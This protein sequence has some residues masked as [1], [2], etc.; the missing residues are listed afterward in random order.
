MQDAKAIGAALAAF[1]PADKIGWKPQ[2]VKNNRAM[3]VAYIDARDV[4]DRLDEAVGPANWQDEYTPLG[5]GSVMCRLSVRFGAEWIVK[6]DV[7]SPSEQP[8]G[9]DRLKAAFSDALK[10]AAVKFGVGRYLYSLPHSWHDYDPAKRQFVN[11]PTLPAKFLPQQQKPAQ[12]KPAA[13]VA[14][15]PQKPAAPQQASNAP[16]RLNGWSNL[17][18]QHFDAIKKAADEGLL[19]TA[20]A[21]VYN[22]H[23]KKELNQTEYA[24][25]EGAKDE[26]KLALA[27]AD[28]GDATCDPPY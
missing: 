8:D 4:M 17:V 10:R 28:A 20:W 25:L 12:Q 1:F 16:D 27:S 13:P 3:A 7:G 26:K 21:N 9:G 11:V 15:T 23:Q 2:A 18:R 5:D 22:C 6:A 14:P 24:F 19:R